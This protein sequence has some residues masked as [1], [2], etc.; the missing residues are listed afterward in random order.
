VSG[1]GD[2]RQVISSTTTDA[3]VNYLLDGPIGVC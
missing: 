1:D 3:S 2:T